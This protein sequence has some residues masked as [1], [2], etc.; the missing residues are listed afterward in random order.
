MKVIEAFYK[1]SQFIA[2]QLAEYKTNEFY[3]ML[4]LK[5]FEITSKFLNLKLKFIFTIQQSEL[6]IYYNFIL[7][8]KV[9]LIMKTF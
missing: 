3:V 9:S 8:F 2:I 1:L 5:F 6:K 7:I 4:V